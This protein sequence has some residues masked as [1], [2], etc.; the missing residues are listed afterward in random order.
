MLLKSDPL[1]KTTKIFTELK[2]KEVKKVIFH[3]EEVKA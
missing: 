2:D 3:S 1:N